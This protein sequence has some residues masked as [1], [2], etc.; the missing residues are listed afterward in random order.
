MP[1][2]G[3]RTNDPIGTLEELK[4]A[5]LSG[6]V[7]RSCSKP[8]SENRGCAYHGGCE[9]AY[10]DTSGPHN[11]GVLKIP[12]S[13][14]SDIVEEPC[15]WVMAKAGDFRQANETYE[16]I[17][18]EGDEIICKGT[19][20]LIIQHPGRKP[21]TKVID[22]PYKKLVEKFPR[23]HENPLLQDDLHNLEVAGVVQKRQ[24]ERRKQRAFGGIPEITAG[25]PAGATFTGI[26]GG[27]DTPDGQG[28]G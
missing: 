15:Y 10:R 27:D 12:F 3:P 28:S 20:E 23:P 18:D 21:S 4:K 9:F 7:Y 17:A 11:H 2:H 19:E 6:M 16:V 5:K 13:G 14:R 24:E 26:E 8:S 1:L 25:V 22:K